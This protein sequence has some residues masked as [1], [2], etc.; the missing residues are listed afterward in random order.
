[1]ATLSISSINGSQITTSSVGE[2]SSSSSSIVSDST[3]ITSSVSLSTETTS[4]SITSINNND[5]LKGGQDNDILTGGNGND[6]LCGNLGT[7]SITGGK[8]ADTFVLTV[9]LA[10]PI[11]NPLL[12][13]VITDFNKSEGDKIGLAQG[14]VAAQ[15]VFEAFDSNSDKK[16]DAILIKLGANANDGILAVVL[17]TIDAAGVTLLNQTDFTT[18]SA[19]IMA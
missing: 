5:T 6:V 2:S 17:G 9:D 8:G 3:T 13:D 18:I 15:L 14:L 16:A 1:M 11:T 7:D 12:A 19:N 4:I 10:N